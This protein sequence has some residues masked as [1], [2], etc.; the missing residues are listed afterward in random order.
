MIEDDKDDDG[1]DDENKGD[2]MRV[3]SNWFLY[4]GLRN[5]IVI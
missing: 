1:D 2:L 5:I 3:E 4:S